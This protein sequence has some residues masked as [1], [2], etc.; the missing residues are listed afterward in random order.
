[1]IHEGAAVTGAR[2]ALRH[3]MHGNGQD[4]SRRTHPQGT[5]Q[6]ASS[7][8]TF[9]VRMNRSTKAVD[10]VERLRVTRNRQERHQ[11]QSLSENRESS[12]AQ[13]RDE[14]LRVTCTTDSLCWPLRTSDVGA[15]VPPPSAHCSRCSAA[16]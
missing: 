5:F 14:S 9:H 3:R 6:L 1:M 11:T 10:G 12:T 13:T 7:F 4:H 8:S 16:Y 15:P 2:P